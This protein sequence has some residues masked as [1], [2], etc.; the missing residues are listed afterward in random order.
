MLSCLFSHYLCV[1]LQVVVE[2]I[3]GD[4][5]IS[6]VEG[7]GPV[8]ALSSK[9]SPLGHHSMEIAQRKQDHLEL[10]LLGALFKSILKTDNRRRKENKMTIPS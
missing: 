5:Q 3:D 10:R 1:G 7:I 6:I 4:G 9:L 2:H 8:P